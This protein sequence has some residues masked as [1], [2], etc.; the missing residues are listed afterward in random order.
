M[1][2]D[3]EGRGSVEF[4]RMRQPSLGCGQGLCGVPI[5]PPWRDL[6]FGLSETVSLEVGAGPDQGVA[7]IW[8][9]GGN[10]QR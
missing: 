7:G 10:G 4:G 6:A 2:I 9:A 1:E 5:V 8:V 3:G